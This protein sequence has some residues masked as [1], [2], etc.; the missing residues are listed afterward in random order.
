MGTDYLG[1]IDECIN[2]MD[3]WLKYKEEPIWKELEDILRKD[4]KMY[5]TQ[6]REM[7]TDRAMI[8]KVKINNNESMIYIPLEERDRCKSVLMACKDAYYKIID[9]PERIIKAGQIAIERRKE[10]LSKKNSSAK[11]EL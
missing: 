10:I 5:S 1:R 7:D 4:I 2:L 3:K 11:S 8:R 9:M 6:I